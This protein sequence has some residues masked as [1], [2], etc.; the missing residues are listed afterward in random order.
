MPPFLADVLTWPGNRSYITAIKAARDFSIPPTVLMLRRKQPADGW[1]DADKKLAIAFQILEDET[2][3]DCG[4]PIWVGHSE[5]EHVVFSIKSR[6]CYSCA[7]IEDERER[8][9]KRRGKRK[10]TKGKKHFVVMEP[11]DHTPSREDYYASQLG[12]ITDD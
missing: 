12:E 5:D 2:C 10:P 1:S 9:E 7:E 4:I 8:G 3:P 11:S 6:V